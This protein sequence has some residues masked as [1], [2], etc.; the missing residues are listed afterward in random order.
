MRQNYNDILAEICE[1]DLLS[2]ILSQITGEELK[3]VAL[4]DRKELAEEI[5]EA[6]Y[7]LS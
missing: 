1:N 4:S 2:S 3:V 7:S 5:R 6:N